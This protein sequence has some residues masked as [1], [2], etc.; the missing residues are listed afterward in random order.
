MLLRHIVEGTAQV[1]LSLGQFVGEDLQAR[2]LGDDPRGVAPLG[3]PHVAVGRVGFSLALKEGG[4]SWVD[5][6]HLPCAEA[7]VRVHL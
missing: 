1:I 2:A 3:D 4:F 7:L 5:G 6:E